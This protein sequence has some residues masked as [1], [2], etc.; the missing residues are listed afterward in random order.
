MTTVITPSDTSFKKN[1]VEKVTFSKTIFCKNP[2]D[3]GLAWGIY[4]CH[5]ESCDGF[6]CCKGSINPDLCI[7]G[8]QFEIHGAW[9]YSEQYKQDQFSFRNFS[10]I[11]P[12]G[13]WGVRAFL[14]N[15]GGIGDQISSRIWQAFGEDSIQSIIETP[16]IVCSKVPGLSIEVA[17]AA[18]ESLA[19]IYQDTKAK[20]PLLDLFKG[21]KLPAKT[22]DRV[23]SAKIPD[24][25]KTI[26]DNPFI[27]SSRFRG[28]GFKQADSL[29][30]KLGQSPKSENR[31]R[32]AC[33]QSFQ[34]SS[35]QT[36]LSISQIKS[37]MSKLL[38]FSTDNV[39]TFIEELVK[40]ETIVRNEYG[41]GEFYASVENY[42]D[43]RHIAGDLFARMAM[44]GD[45][46]IE[47]IESDEVLSAHQKEVLLH[48]IK[49]GGRVII[50]PGSPGTG[51]TFTAGRLIKHFMT[52]FEG[53]TFAALAPTGKAAS[54]LSHILQSNGIDQ[55]AT[56]IHKLLEPKPIDGGFVFSRSNH[57]IN[58]TLVVVDEA[59]MVSNNLCSALLQGLGYGCN[60]IF[61]G[62]DNQL[63]PVGPGTMFRDMKQ[64]GF[65]ELVE[66]ERNAG[67]GVRACK[68]LREDVEMRYHMTTR[69]L[70]DV[71]KETNLHQ[72]YA[73]KDEDKAKKIREIVQAILN[74]DIKVNDKLNDIQFFT[75][76]HNNKHVGR[77][78]LNEYL[79]SQFNPNGAGEHKK[80]KVGDKIINTENGFYKVITG[81]DVDGKPIFRKEEIMVPNGE[82]AIVTKSEKRKIEAKISIDLKDK[83]GNKIPPPVIF[84]PCGEE[85]GS[86]DLGYVITIHKS[87]GSEW[88][89][90]VT[91]IGSDFGSEMV[92][93]REWLTT[94]FSRY[95]E[96]SCVI[97]GTGQ[98]SKIRK[99]V[100][101]WERKSFLLE[102]MRHYSEKVK[103]NL[104]SEVEHV[105]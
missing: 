56:T 93:C 42:L 18:S 54:R 103:Q 2:G 38:E 40:S 3:D 96:C 50:L 72:V 73:N 12:N 15:A 65:R 11:V 51:K 90:T 1:K 25:V 59:W 80:F 41:D 28:I 48:N 81:Y 35:D 58:P 105:D 85:G 83:D 26:S 13:E 76:T 39:Q 70:Q 101:T 75:A 57:D 21:T 89:K 22:A 19:K 94:A 6:K 8:A 52:R 20:L 16:E 32:A 47:E 63:P 71:E 55:Y 97:S 24:P 29:R 98:I 64:L 77:V 102:T 37:S 23:L 88:P 84:I 100:R 61:I 95:K 78:A 10:R 86:W 60:I 49:A 62:D 46:P 79:Q 17:N 34:D 68:A 45:W 44:K 9:E 87:Q 104:P 67:M 53:S 14:M 92:T 4:L 27:L 30:I 31:I 43:E 36:W 33:E 5:F 74:G 69:P 99:R 82:M 66:I 91:V 7:K